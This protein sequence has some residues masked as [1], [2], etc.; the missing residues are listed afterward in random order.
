MK[1]WVKIVIG[2]AILLV[3]YIIWVLVAPLEGKPIGKDIFTEF[4]CVS[5]KIILTRC[6][7]DVRTTCSNP[8]C[9]SEEDYER[10]IRPGIESDGSWHTVSSED[11][12]CTIPTLLWVESW[13]HDRPCIIIWHNKHESL[14]SLGF[15]DYGKDVVKTVCENPEYEYRCACATKRLLY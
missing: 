9:V 2:I 3:L 7:V 6:K 8:A 1:N 4:L 15:K 12:S 11:P 10:C 13:G 14:E 5:Q